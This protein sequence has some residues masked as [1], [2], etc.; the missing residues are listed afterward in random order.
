MGDAF[1]VGVVVRDFE[2]PKRPVAVKEAPKRAGHRHGRDR[3]LHQSRGS[4][5]GESPTVH[6]AF[7]SKS[8][9]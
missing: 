6:S 2:E 1:K 4:P 8:I 5:T 7:S 9:Y 3:S